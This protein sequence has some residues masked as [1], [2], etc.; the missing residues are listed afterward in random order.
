[1]KL[2]TIK[3][4]NRIER[5]LNFDSKIELFNNHYI[6]RCQDDYQPVEL[7]SIEK[8]AVIIDGKKEHTMTIEDFKIDEASS[9]VHVYLSKTNK[10]NKFAETEEF[11][12]VNSNLR[13]EYVCKLLP[14][15][16]KKWE[17][18]FHLDD[19]T[20]SIFLYCA[21]IVYDAIID[22]GSEASQACWFKDENQHNINLT[23]SIMNATL[24]HAKASTTKITTTVT[25]SQ[26]QDS[27]IVST[28]EGEPSQTQDSTPVATAT[29]SAQNQHPRTPK[30]YYQ[31]ESDTLYKS[32]YYIKKDLGDGTTINEWPDYGDDTIKF[33]VSNT[34]EATKLNNDYLLIP[35]SKLFQFD[36]SNYTQM[37]VKRKGKKIALNELD[38]KIVERILLN[39]IVKQVLL[40]IQ[41]NANNSGHDAY[42]V[43]NVL[44]PNVY[45]IHITANK[46]NQLAKDIRTLLS[47]SDKEAFDR[48]KAVELQPISES[49]ASLLGHVTHSIESEDDAI[50]EGN[51]LIMD[52]GKGTLDFSVMEVSEGDG[53]VNKNRSGI[54]G[55]GNAVTY[56]LIIGLINDYL[57]HM[58][59][60]YNDKTP[61][62]KHRLIQQF[63]FE[64]IL[65]GK[66]TARFDIA[67]LLRFTNAVEEYKKTYNLLYINKTSDIESIQ[68][69]TKSDTFDSLTLQ[70]FT[71]WVNELS[72]KKTKLTR[73]SCQYV[74]YEIEN[75]VAEAM[76]KMKSI[77]SNT[78]L[79][80]SGKAPIDYVVFTGR[81]FLM[82]Q[83]QDAMW[84]SLA[85][86][87][88][89]DRPPLIPEEE[90]MKIGCLNINQIL[91]GDK[92]DSSPSRQTVGV[93]NRIKNSDNR[94]AQNAASKTN[95]EEKP[96]KQRNKLTPY[97]IAG[98]GEGELE[99]EGKTI[100]NITADSIVYIGGWG[101]SIPKRFRRK[102]CK[103]FFDGSNY[104]ITAKGV[105]SAALNLNQNAKY[106]S[107]L[108]FESL[109]P[110]VVI[111]SQ[112]KV[113]IPQA[114]D[115][116]AIEE[117]QEDDY[118]V[119][120]VENPEEQNPTLKERF[121]DQV[122]DGISLFF[123]AFGRKPV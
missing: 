47:G 117:K 91:I 93:L 85:D 50:D 82:K 39:N 114:I 27:A 15:T 122:K 98:E 14:P 110:N 84:E 19:K 75:I 101:Y 55:A 123:K 45:P 68:E 64:K 51:Y 23:E 58:M 90:Q 18:Q 48:I 96:D 11:E 88:K 100:K 62:Q 102:N 89:P 87:V 86:F 46:L 120:M 43:L 13:N 24:T 57:S 30:D 99:K 106:K 34:E 20:I 29:T 37:T 107:P 26:T 1:M 79:D 22:F 111:D 40:A 60:G 6:I 77:F 97:R 54:I 36:L 56:G 35:N 12:L 28:T 8:G 52:A 73:E 33:L 7:F 38:N 67:N 116:K 118:I 83:L 92:Y 94:A 105:D 25:T 109:F 16:S 49:D 66:N 113:V 103:I 72:T 44:M 63:V 70:G 95:S 9:I 53:Y 5:K 74:T 32:I 59:T 112:D 115:K 76:K 81:G 42:L 17:V 71:S 69:S 21:S 10:S 4:N 41:D 2:V 65:S 121:I 119:S 3:I 108:C 61:E 104:W 78:T 80:K 31:F